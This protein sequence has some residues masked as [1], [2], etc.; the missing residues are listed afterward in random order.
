MK[1]S[2]VAEIVCESLRKA[3][4][5]KNSRYFANLTFNIKIQER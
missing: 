5:Q 3:T 1:M 2:V 4:A